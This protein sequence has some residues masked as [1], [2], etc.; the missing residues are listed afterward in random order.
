MDSIRVK[1]CGVLIGELHLA[2]RFRVINFPFRAPNVDT[3]GRSAFLADKIHAR[4]QSPAEDDDEFLN[5]REMR[6]R[7]FFARCSRDF[8]Y[9][10]LFRGLF[11]CER[12]A[13]FSNLKQHH[14]IC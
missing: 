2:P 12:N 4:L 7:D 14:P 13:K 9:C 8:S 1:I 10:V 11:C 6:V 5:R 3:F